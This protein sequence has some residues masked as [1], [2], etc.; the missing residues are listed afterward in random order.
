ML[1]NLHV[2]AV[3][4][5]YKSK[6]SIHFKKSNL[7]GMGRFL[8]KCLLIVFSWQMADSTVVAASLCVQFYLSKGPY[9]CYKNLSC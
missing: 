7:K 2:A 9:K 8:S 5:L 6:F 4:S 1:G 3:S